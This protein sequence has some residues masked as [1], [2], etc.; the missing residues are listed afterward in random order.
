MIVY[1]IN[2]L[3]HYL[4]YVNKKAGNAQ[5]GILLRQWNEV[6]VSICGQAIE[7]Q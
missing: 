3:K 2:N 4:K 7:A 1:H 6:N 5:V